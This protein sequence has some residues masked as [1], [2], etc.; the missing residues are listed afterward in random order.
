METECLG[1]KGEK[2]EVTDDGEIWLECSV[3]NKR[4]TKQVTRRVDQ[5]RQCV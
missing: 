1:C 2:F 4:V 3:K 5:D